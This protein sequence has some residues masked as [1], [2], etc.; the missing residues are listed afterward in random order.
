MAPFRGANARPPMANGEPVR[1]PA[2][3]GNLL[4][5]RGFPLLLAGVLLA[6]VA[7][8]STN[9]APSKSRASSTAKST[10]ARKYAAAKSTAHAKS[11][12]ATAKSA[13]AKTTAAH[14]GT[15][16]ST[17]H[18]ASAAHTAGSH[19]TK[20]VAASKGGT[21]ARTAGKS[22]ASL[23]KNRKSR[24]TPRPRLQAAPTPE[25]YQEIQ[26]AL[27][28]RGFF[29]GEVNGKWGPDSVEALKEFQT[30]QKLTDDGKIS[31]LSLIGLGLGPKHTYA[32]APVPPSGANAGGSDS[33]AS[34]AATS[35]QGSAS[36]GPSG[37]PGAASAPGAPASPATGTPASPSPASGPD[38]GD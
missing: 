10:A 17:H 3:L 9:T 18:A 6:S 16:A 11:T 7:V 21:H 27:A 2:N 20:A 19:S 30:S 15:T 23:A 34:P 38:K 25:R 1:Y 26:Q 14:R 33:N 8:A 5:R 12:G 28:D 37:N 4:D 31:S 35:P 29:K 32:A 24:W 13:H 22:G 36:P